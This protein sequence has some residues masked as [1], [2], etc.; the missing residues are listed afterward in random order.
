LLE[1]LDEREFLLVEGRVF[2]DGEHEFA[3]LPF[4]QLAGDVIYK[5]FIAGDGQSI[6]WVE[7]CEVSELVGE[8]MA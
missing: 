3:R 5:E 7:V 1:C 4:L 2:G 8:L 6:L